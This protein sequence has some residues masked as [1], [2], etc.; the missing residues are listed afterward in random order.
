MALITAAV[1]PAVLVPTAQLN[2]RM[3]FLPAP[4]TGGGSGKPTPTTGQLWPR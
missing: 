1:A 3:T 4:P 2:K